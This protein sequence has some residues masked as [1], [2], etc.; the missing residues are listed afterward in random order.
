MARNE[1]PDRLSGSSFIGS[2]SPN[3][4]AKFA[5]FVATSVGVLV[6]ARPGFLDLHV[7]RSGGYAW[8]H[9]VGLYSESFPDLVPG[10]S[11]P[12]TYPP[13]AAIIFSPLSWLPW[14]ASKMVLTL[15]SAGLIY[16]IFVTTGRRIGVFDQE[17]QTTWRMLI[18]SLLALIA[19][20]PIRQTLSFGQ[21]NIIL[22]AL[23]V[24]NCLS[25]NV[26][27]PRGM[28]VGLAAAV[29]LTPAVF[30]AFFLIQKNYRAALVSVLSFASFGVIGFILARRDSMDYWFYELWNPDRIGGAAYAFNQSFMA[31]LSRLRIDD[32]EVRNTLWLSLVLGTFVLAVIGARRYFR[33]GDPAGA[34]LVVAAWG[35]LASPV[36][37]SH[38]WVWAAPG[39]LMLA[40]RAIKGTQFVRIVM[41]AVAAIFVVGPHALL[42][43]SADNT[44]EQHW[45]W[46]QHVVGSSYVLVALG[47]LIVSVTLRPTGI[48]RSTISGDPGKRG[49][50]R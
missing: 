35:L 18:A 43:Y 31:V 1:L 23:V 21:I 22:M 6:I 9:G 27:W 29:K 8:L 33:A 10:S 39:L 45:V 13:F 3:R 12:F 19:I 15:A 25:R 41:I 32:L 7:Y 11:P 2:T 17:D 34:L 20:E 42:P 14:H 26:K 50:S 37:W 47:L 46:W 36:S 30:V 49:E 48:K 40:Y 38:H 16:R 5:I 24:V 28:L 4:A 44:A